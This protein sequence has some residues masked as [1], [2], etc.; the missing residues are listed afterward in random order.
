MK[1]LIAV[2][3]LIAAAAA[4]AQC[5]EPTVAE[6]NPDFEQRLIQLLKP[7]NVGSFGYT[8]QTKP[9]VLLHMS[10]IH[11]DGEEFAR[12]AEFYTAYE[13]YFDGAI[14]TGDLVYFSALSDFT[15]WGKTP[16]HEKIMNI[17]GNHDV[18]STH[19]RDVK[20]EQLTMNQAY[21][22]YMAPFIDKWG[23]V[24][25]RG[26]TYWYKDYPEKK[27]R[28]IG[29]D[30]MLHPGADRAAADG[31]YEWFKKALA[32]AKTRDL[33]V[34]TA[35]HY[36]PQK[37]VKIDSLF[38]DRDKQESAWGDDSTRY[39]QAVDDFMNDGGKFVCWLCGHLHWEIF[40]YCAD[41]PKQLVRCG[42]AA[43]RVQ[44]AGY[45]FI[46]RG[47][48]LRSMDLA[49]AVVVDTSTKTLKILRVG[50]NRD[51]YLRP[52]NGIVINYETMEIVS[53]Y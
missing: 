53:Q 39:R 40:G 7:L 44:C 15:Y 31:Q 10:D 14:C 3:A 17:I 22:R 41:Y 34:I 37:L 6:L 24:N 49:D 33:N 52:R 4:C 35:F 51:S 11:G 45:G 28:L 8:A 9:F 29:L 48:G 47:D 25:E 30:C 12:L 50:A 18:L 21:L 38:T 13:K 46:T 1:K 20:R 26:T 32:G 23:V 42:G 43:N 16:G 5:A 27:I 2:I 19:A 36:Q